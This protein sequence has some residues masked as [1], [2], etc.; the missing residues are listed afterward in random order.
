MEEIE[1]P[2]WHKNGGMWVRRDCLEPEH[3]ASYYNYIKNELGLDP[4]DYGYYCTQLSEEQ[5]KLLS[6][7]PNDALLREVRLRERAFG[8]EEMYG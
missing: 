2:V 3:P 4:E 5:A 1:V 6:S 7:I 8:M